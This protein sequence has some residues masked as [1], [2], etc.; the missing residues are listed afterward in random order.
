MILT[1]DRRGA[2]GHKRRLIGLISAIALG[3]SF[4][5]GTLV[6]GDTMRASFDEVFA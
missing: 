5:T 2:L 1:L 3:V 4:L 6:L